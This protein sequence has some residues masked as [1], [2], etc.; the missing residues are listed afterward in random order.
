MTGLTQSDVKILLWKTALRGV[1][2]LA[3]LSVFLFVSVG[4]LNA[5]Q[6]PTGIVQGETITLDRA[7]ALAIAH[8][9]SILASRSTVEASQ[10]RI[11]QAQANYWPQIEASSGYTRGYTAGITSSLRSGAYDQYEGTLTG[12]QKIYDF[13]RTA[14]QVGV[15][16][17]STE[18]ARADLTNTVDQTVLNLKVAYFG[19]LQAQRNR[20]VTVET[21]RQF[22][23]HLDQARGF[24]EVG[25]KAKFDVTKA[26]VDLSNAR[27]NQIRAENAVRVARVGLDNAMGLPAAPGYEVEDVLTSPPYDITLE[28]ALQQA[29][30]V[31]P[32]LQS[33]LAK[34]KAAEQ[35]IRLAKAGYYPSLDGSATYG[36]GGSDFPLRENWTAGA[37]IS[38]P[39]FNGFLT[40]HQIDE[41][42]ANFRTLMANEAAIRQTIAYD[43]QQA[44]L[45]LS[46]AKERIAVAEVT[47][48]QATENLDLANGRYAAG[49]GSPIEVTDA[50]VSLSNARM[51]YNQ[52][53]YDYRIAQA[54]MDKARGIRN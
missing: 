46:E 20:Q 27:L 52:A 32:D 40:K 4:P 30:A 9:P 37:T 10:S 12:T 18:A 15:Q 51:S 21:T 53:L 31:R 43:V 45:S 5:Q 48:R 29:Y 19:L 49:V 14:S 44:F 33:I 47:V 13:G 34:K 41:A 2:G 17:F 3:G 38:V 25:T 54:T 8:H 36:W 26:E 24:F 11:G 28:S 23:Q 7:V 42:Q 1:L 22:Q 16:K 6:P 39:L 35:S 50:L